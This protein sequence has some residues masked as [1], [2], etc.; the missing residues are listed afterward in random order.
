MKF[1]V[2]S[3]LMKIWFNVFNVGFNVSIFQFFQCFNY[4]NVDNGQRYCS[5]CENLNS[6]KYYFVNCMQSNCIFSIN[7]NLNFLFWLKASIFSFILLK[8]H[9]EHWNIKQYFNILSQ[10]IEFNTMSMWKMEKLPMSMSIFS[11]F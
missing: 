10:N 1:N 3:M 11:M 9:W 6:F 2:M 7:I 4:F 8:K 5:I